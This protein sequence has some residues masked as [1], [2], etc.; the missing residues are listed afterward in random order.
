M[1]SG[2][3]ISADGVAPLG[4]TTSMG[5]SG[6]YGG[7]MNALQNSYKIDSPSSMG[8]NTSMFESKMSGPIWKGGYIPR[9]VKKRKP[10]KGTFGFPTKMNLFAENK[11]K[12][13]GK[14]VTKISHEYNTMLYYVNVK[15]VKTLRNCTLNYFLK[16]YS[17]GTYILIVRGHAFTVKDGSVIGNTEDAKKTK[18]H[19]VGAW[20]IG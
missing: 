7:N 6:S 13:N 19:I 5:V 15:G 14:G 2:T 11:I 10:R 3:G 12:F 8:G 18:K 1:A 4:S 9:T 17:T 20:K 16:K